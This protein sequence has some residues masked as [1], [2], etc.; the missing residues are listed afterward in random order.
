MK[1]R[2]STCLLFTPVARFVGQNEEGE[3]GDSEAN[4]PCGG[5]MI[6]M[7][8]QFSHI[9]FDTRFR[10]LS[11]LLAADDEVGDGDMN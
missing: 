7:E 1:H 6:L 8:G 11:A 3:T 9:G 5:N 4:L 10:L 2:W